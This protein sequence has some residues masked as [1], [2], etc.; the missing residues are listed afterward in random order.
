MQQ[1]LASFEPLGGGN[2]GIGSLS[3]HWVDFPGL[4]VLGKRR[5]GELGH[6][7][8]SGVN[9]CCSTVI[10]LGSMVIWLSGADGAGVQHLP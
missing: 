8:C 2:R 10:T 6:A 1:R 7:C 3:F 5:G 4:S 9:I